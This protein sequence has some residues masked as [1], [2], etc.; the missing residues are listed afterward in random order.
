MT[1]KQVEEK[2]TELDHQEPF[3]PFV[4]DLLD[5][6]SLMLTH[7]PVFDETGAGYFDPDGG[8]ADF[9]FKAVRGI[10]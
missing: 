2:L 9:E 8:L 5:G 4:V 1:N 7:P 6:Q 10:R 3:I